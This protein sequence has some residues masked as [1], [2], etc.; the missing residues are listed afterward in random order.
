MSSAGIA[1]C[2]L[3]CLQMKQ[4]LDLQ[5]ILVASPK[6]I[7]SRNHLRTKANGISSSNAWHV[8]V[9]IDAPEL[10]VTGDVLKSQALS[11]QDPIL[12]NLRSLHQSGF[13][14][15]TG[16]LQMAGSIATR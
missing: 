15:E 13:E 14:Q 3:Y 10:N 1:R 6:R 12:K 9:E 7:A 11:F 8:R 4:L 16:L 2:D 5:T